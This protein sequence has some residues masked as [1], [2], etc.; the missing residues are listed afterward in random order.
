MAFAILKKKSFHQRIPHQHCTKRIKISSLN[1]SILTLLAFAQQYEDCCY[2]PPLSTAHPR[3]EPRPDSAPHSSECPRH[4]ARWQICP[5]HRRRGRRSRR[6][7]RLGARARQ[8]PAMMMT[9]QILS[10]RSRHSCSQQ[11]ID[12]NTWWEARRE[13]NGIWEGTDCLMTIKS[14][15]TTN[16]NDYNNTTFISEST[17]SQE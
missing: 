8:N 7:A 2:P 17:Y 6:D 13:T 14:E 12:I 9:Q 11:R 5:V 10:Q 3:V 1:Y 16:V 15:Q 4:G